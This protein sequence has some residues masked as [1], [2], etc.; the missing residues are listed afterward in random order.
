VKLTP[1]GRNCQ[2][3]YSNGTVPFAYLQLELID[4]SSEKVNKIFKNVYNHKETQAFS[5]SNNDN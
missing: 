2:M 3:I 1:G 5:F 4:S